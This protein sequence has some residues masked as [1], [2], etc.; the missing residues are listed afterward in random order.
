MGLCGS[1]V[2]NSGP[3]T[4][5]II[6]GPGGTGKS[7][8]FKQGKLHHGDGFSEDEL[9]V[10]KSVVRTLLLDTLRVLSRNQTVQ[11]TMSDLELEKVEE[12]TFPCQ[13]QP[14]SMLR[15]I[16]TSSLATVPP[17]PPLHAQHTPGRRAVG[18]AF[19]CMQE[20]C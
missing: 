11:A 1:S 12:G 18:W 15:A 16:I 14:T 13:K 6:I 8:L 5:L 9:R 3:A 20:Q 7:T 17:L 10:G 19:A 4:R 2:A